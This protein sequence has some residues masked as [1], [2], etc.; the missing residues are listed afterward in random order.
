[1][2]VIFFERIVN[3]SSKSLDFFKNH[4]VGIPT[5]V[6]TIYFCIWELGAVGSW[7]VL[8]SVGPAGM[9]TMV[10]GIIYITNH[11]PIPVT[12]Q[13]VMVRSVTIH[14]T[15]PHGVYTL[16]VTAHMTYTVLSC[17]TLFSYNLQLYFY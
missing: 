13:I 14:Y 4:S 11:N 7:E 3:K 8:Q 16:N 2:D 9:G 12:T 6:V 1:M 5:V 10:I 15:L 17:G